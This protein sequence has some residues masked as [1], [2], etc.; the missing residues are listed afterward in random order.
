MS[1]SPAPT[2]PS[3][4]P[5]STTACFRSGPNSVLAIDR[6]S[7]DSTTHD[8]QFDASLKRGTLAV[9]SGRMVKQSP[10]SMRVRTPSSD[11]GRAR[12]R[13]RRQ[14]RRAGAVAHGGGPRH[15]GAASCA[16]SPLRRA[17]CRLAPR[18]PSSWWSVPGATATPA[19]SSSSSDGK[20]TVL[21]QPYAANRI[22]RDGGRDAAHRAGSAQ[23]VRRRA[24]GDSG[25]PGLVPA[26]LR[27][28]HRRAHRGIERRA[29]AHA[30]GAAPPPGARHPGDRAYR[31]R[32]QRRGQRPAV[33]RARR[34]GARRPGRAGHRAPSASRPP[35][36]ASASR[37]CRPPTTST[38][39]A[40]GA[41][42]STSARNQPAPFQRTQSSVRSSAC[43]ASPAKRRTSSRTRAIASAGS[44][45][46][47]EQAPSAAPRRRARRARSI[48]SVTPSVTTHSDSPGASAA[49]ARWRR[50]SRPP[51][52]AAA[53][54]ACSQA[55]GRAAGPAEVRRLV[56]G[57]AELEHAGA[58]V[59]HAGE[60][61]D[62]EASRGCRARSRRLP[63]PGS[64]RI[65]A[66]AQRDALQERLGERHE[67]A[68]RAAPCPRRRPPRR[69]GDS[70]STMKQS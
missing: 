68:R 21:N 7:F 8:G 41:S 35:A 64:R 69:T 60:R 1:W 62:E 9:V 53:R 2:A 20:R 13:V 49:A 26:V 6:Y 65:G 25:A 46:L 70:A 27:H 36:A 47:L 38:S 42:R 24:G 10:E 23:H 52:T 51:R 58:R 16:R 43:S 3:A 45:A 50:R 14:G 66:A 31:P 63:A 61:G 44:S 34:A 57:V 54:P 37:S 39:R 32:R 56:P 67:K 59:E 55:L 29:R 17:G 4:S 11:H 15:H 33:A 12:H 19:P 18:P 5:S 40:T 48:A 22:G 30:R 28:R